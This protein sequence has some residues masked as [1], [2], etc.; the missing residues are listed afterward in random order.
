[1]IVVRLA[2][3]CSGRRKPMARRIGGYWYL[4]IAGALGIFASRS[5]RLPMTLQTSLGD[6]RSGLLVGV[7]VRPCRLLQ[8]SVLN[9]STWAR[10]G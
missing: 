6:G 9:I 1:V 3:G 7:S 10:S 2:T 4:A 8:N 5:G